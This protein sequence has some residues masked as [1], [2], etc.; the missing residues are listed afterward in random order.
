MPIGGTALR[1]DRGHFPFYWIV[2]CEGR[3]ID[4]YK[5]G[6]FVLIRTDPFPNYQTEERG[7][8]VRHRIVN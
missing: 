1:I 2:Y 6:I 5:I 4:F 7:S 3:F 8:F